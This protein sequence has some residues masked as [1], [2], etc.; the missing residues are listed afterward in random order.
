MPLPERRA[1]RKPKLRELVEAVKALIRGPYTSKFPATPP[2]IPDGFRG[3]PEYR[4]ADCVGCGACAEVCPARA[5]TMTDDAER[6]V[7]RLS[8]RYDNC[9]YCQTCERACITKEGIK[10][11]KRWNLVTTDRPSI[12][13]AVVKDL[14][15]CE[16]C[17]GVVGARDHLLWV[18]ER[19][20]PLGFANPSLMLA[21]MGSLGL[22]EPVPPPGD[23]PLVRGDRIRVLCPRCRQETALEA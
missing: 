21:K 20:G 17:D 22:D 9:I 6:R 15:L 1:M 10:L 18:A 23:R 12:E 19:L 7:R 11:S 8:L 2:E 16:H 3:A 14:V 13:A 5:I 4:E